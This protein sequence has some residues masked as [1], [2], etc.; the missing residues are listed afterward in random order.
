MEESKLAR[1]RLEAARSTSA[2]VLRQQVFHFDPAVSGAMPSGPL[3]FGMVGVV[4]PTGKGIGKQG[5]A[6]GRISDE[7]AQEEMLKNIFPGWF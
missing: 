2:S 1:M 3:G 7:H 5:Q 6:R 4:P